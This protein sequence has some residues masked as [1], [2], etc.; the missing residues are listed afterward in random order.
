MAGLSYC[1]FFVID[2]LGGIF[3]QREN[4][5]RPNGCH[6]SFCMSQAIW[7]GQVCPLREKVECYCFTSS[8]FQDANLIPSTLLPT[9]D[10]PPLVGVST[11]FISELSLR[12]SLND[13]NDAAT[14][15]GGKKCGCINSE[16][17]QLLQISKLRLRVVGSGF[18]KVIRI[19][20]GIRFVSHK[21]RMWINYILFVL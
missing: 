2:Q 20:E 18:A 9:S 11:S 3:S 10:C 4:W 12:Q 17:F 15:S 14:P 21:K 13:S 19:F 7:R 16:L 8:F 1:P 5:L 6:P